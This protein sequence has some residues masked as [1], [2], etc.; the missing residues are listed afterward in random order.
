MRYTLIRKLVCI[1]PV[2][3][4]LAACGGGDSTPAPAPAPVPPGPPPVVTPAG[5]A[6]GTPVSASLGSAGGMLSSADGRLQLVVPEGALSAPTTIS[7]QPVSNGAPGRVGSGY[8]LLP[9][10]I[11]FARPVQ[12]SFAYDESDV[13]GSSAELLGVATQQADGTWRWQGG[14]LDAQA[15][16]VTASATHFSDWSLVK[17]LQLRPPSATVKTRA[18]V[19]LKLA[20]CFAPALDNDLLEPLGFDC[21]AENAPAPRQA[22][23]WSV[24]GI[25]GGNGSAGTVAG[26]KGGAIYTAP[27]QVPPTNPVAV[28]AEIQG[29][30][31]KVLVV[32]NITVKGDEAAGYAGSISGTVTE[33]AD[34]TRI[35]YQSANL[36]FVPLETPPTNYAARG[37]LTMT[38]YHPGGDVTTRL[39][40]LEGDGSVLTVHDPVL[41]GPYASFSGRYWFSVMGLFNACPEKAVM[42]GTA[43]PSY[44]A[45]PSRLEGTRQISCAGG[46]LAIDAQWSLK[47][48]DA[49]P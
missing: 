28:S 10:G 21:E 14:T 49:G 46:S 32:S 42:D 27:A 8:R 38:T 31:G 5:T 15:R 18:S 16:T 47:A 37:S 48:D 7:I 39:V 30:G 4:A 41:E 22:V 36:R 35:A 3:M 40:N 24:N 11:T 23:N 43:L 33:T 9:E 13:A 6:Q 45:D 20:Y 44:G 19:S 26:S 2:L 17:G 12:L 29:A 25:P 34:G 1:A